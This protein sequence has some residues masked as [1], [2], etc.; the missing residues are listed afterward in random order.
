MSKYKS[1]IIVI[2]LSSQGCGLLNG[3]KVGQDEKSPSKGR[4]DQGQGRPPI[5]IHPFIVHSSRTRVRMNQFF[6]CKFI[7]P[8]VLKTKI[9]EFI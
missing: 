6:L 2:P 9:P 3:P 1:L 8:N 4:D 7:S 5:I